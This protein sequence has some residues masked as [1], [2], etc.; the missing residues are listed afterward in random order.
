MSKNKSV[1]L[2]EFGTGVLAGLAAE[3]VNAIPTA[4]LDKAFVKAADKLLES[5]HKL[6][7]TM[8]IDKKNGAPEAQSAIVKAA[9]NGLGRFDADGLFHLNIHRN[10]VELYFENLPLSEKVWRGA[11][12]LVVAQTGRK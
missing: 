9:T 4:E 5:G 8:K 1:S 6:D 3:G 12:A 2:A 11:A 10:D 7:F